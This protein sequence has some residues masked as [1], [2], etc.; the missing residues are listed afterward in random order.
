MRGNQSWF[1]VFFCEVGRENEHCCLHPIVK[2][3]KMRTSEP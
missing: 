1:D 3:H 2:C